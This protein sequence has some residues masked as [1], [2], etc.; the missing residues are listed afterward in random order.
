MCG[1]YTGGWVE[2]DD[3]ER[4]NKNIQFSTLKLP[5][6]IRNFWSNWNT[7]NSI[8]GGTFNTCLWLLKAVII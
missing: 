8:Y 6:K 4:L 5:F 2:K 1:N 7:N 3:Q